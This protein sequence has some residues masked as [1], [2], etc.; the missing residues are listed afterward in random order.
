MDNDKV[1]LIIVEDT[2]LVRLHLS[3]MAK[4]M[5]YDVV[6]NFSSGEDVINFLNEHIDNE[7]DCILMDIMLEGDLDGIETA[8]II[9]EDH[10]IPIIYMSALSDLE[11]LSRADKTNSFKYIVKPFKEDEVKETI[12]SCVARMN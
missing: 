10:D 5:G 12:E 8:K 9:N 6:A 3:S 1:K 4:Q 2:V 11:T 7:C